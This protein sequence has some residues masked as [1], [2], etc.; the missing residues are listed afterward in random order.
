M[1]FYTDLVPTSSGVLCKNY[2]FH[3]E[4]ENDD[5]ENVRLRETNAAGRKP[6][7]MWNVIH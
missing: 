4:K 6:E 3:T 7:I 1:C 2:P 5:Q